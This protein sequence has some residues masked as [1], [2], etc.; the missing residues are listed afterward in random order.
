MTLYIIE[1]SGLVC[2][3][4]GD[5]CYGT[6]S[7]SQPLPQ[8]PVA[9]FGTNMFPGQRPVPAVYP[10][11]VDHRKLY[12][13]DCC[14]ISRFNR[15]ACMAW[16]LIGQ[17]RKQGMRY[18]HIHTQKFAGKSAVL[19]SRHFFGRLRLQVVKVPEPTPAPPPTYLGRLR[20]QA[21]R[22]GSGSIHWHFSF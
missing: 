5:L 21:R 7:R 18:I 2:F 15:P 8:S 17:S 12:S 11:S 4:V 9:R 6:S 3:R 10:R 16:F 22:G 13:A 1:S 20:L 14:G 19:Q